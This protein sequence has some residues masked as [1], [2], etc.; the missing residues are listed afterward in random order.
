ME[1]SPGRGAP[2]GGLFTPNPRF[3]I[4][5]QIEAAVIDLLKGAGYSP[6]EIYAIDTAEAA[7][8][9]VQSG[10]ISEATIRR[11][12]VLAAARRKYRKS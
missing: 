5:I 4:Y 11:A 10:L 2:F 7:H 12:A 6:V 9:V 3:D 1:Q 8:S